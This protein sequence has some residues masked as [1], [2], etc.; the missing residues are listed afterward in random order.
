MKNKIIVEKILKYI[1][2]V[3]NYTE[4]A[5]YDEFVCN[6]MM[7]E[8]CVFNLGQIGELANKIDKKFETLLQ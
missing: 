5:T 2:K 3:K 4:N 8:A 6:S 7:V 1:K